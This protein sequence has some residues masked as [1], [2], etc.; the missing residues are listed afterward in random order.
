MPLV[1]CS[2][3]F[4]FLPKVQRRKTKLFSDL[5]RHIFQP[6]IISVVKMQFSS[7]NRVDGVDYDMTVNGLRIRVRGNDAL[8]IWEH[9]FDTGS[10]V[11]MYHA[12]IGSIF[13]V[14]GEFE[15]IIL[16]L[17]VVR[18]FSE[19]RRRFFELRGIVLVNEK[20]LHVDVFRLILTG[21]VAYSHI[22]HGFA[23]RTFQ[24]RHFSFPRW[25]RAKRGTLSCTLPRRTIL[26]LS[27]SGG[28]DNA[29]PLDLSYCLAV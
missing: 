3:V 6:R 28:S 10:R 18:I 17:V 8:A 11:L 21:N 19:P 27:H 9:L 2:V 12:G 23:R 15:V 16:S 14:G 4:R 7:R 24:K 20:I 13:P 26:A 25:R 22:R 29:E 5:V 1:L